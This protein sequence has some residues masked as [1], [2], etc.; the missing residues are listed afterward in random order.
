MTD[1][2]PRPSVSRRREIGSTSARSLLMTMLGPR[3]PARLLPE[4]WSGAMAADLFHARHADWHP[5]AQRH[6]ERLTA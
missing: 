1:G 4:N 5:A 6:R 3:L 2:T